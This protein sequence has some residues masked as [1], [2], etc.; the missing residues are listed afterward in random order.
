[1]SCAT[2]F[3]QLHKF[4]VA[5][6]ACNWILV[7]KPKISSS[8]G[9]DEIPSTLGGDS[10]MPILPSLEMHSFHAIFDLNVILIAICFNKGGYGKVAS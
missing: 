10:Q 9:L 8:V 6:V 1:M 4:A 2:C 5:C 7:A 3:M